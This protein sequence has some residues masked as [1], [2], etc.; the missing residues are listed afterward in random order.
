MNFYPGTSGFSY[1]EW[2][3]PFYPEDLPVQQMLRFYG[4]RRTTGRGA[5]E[6][7]ARVCALAAGIFSAVV[8]R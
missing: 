6:S 8:A 4:A 2:K 7:I 1:P 3:G 5:L